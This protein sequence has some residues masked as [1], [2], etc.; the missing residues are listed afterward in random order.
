M[1]SLIAANLLHI[2]YSMMLKRYTAT[3]NKSLPNVRGV[4]YKNQTITNLE[5]KIFK[6]NPYSAHVIS[7]KIFNTNKD[8]YA[9]DG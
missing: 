2:Y 8:M 7:I 9:Y 5:M 3:R 6:I 4:C 1:N